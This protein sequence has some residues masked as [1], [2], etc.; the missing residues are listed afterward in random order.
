MAIEEES[1]QA[2]SDLRIERC[3][4]APANP[5]GGFVL[6]WM[7]A[8]RRTTWNHSLGRALSWARKFRKPLVVLEAV[9]C[10]Y[11][12]ASDRLHHFLIDGMA[13][14]ARRFAG[15]GVLYY[16]YVEP[17]KGAGKGLLAALAQHACVVVTDDFP[18]GFLPRMV[19]AAAEQSPVLL[20]QV[21]SNGLLPLRAAETVFTTAYSFR[22][23]LQRELPR[24][25]DGLPEADPL[26]RVM[27]PPIHQLPNEIANRW[28]AAD[29]E[30]LTGSRAALRELPINHDV[31]PVG[32]KGGSLAGFATLARF[33]TRRLKR[34]DELRRDPGDGTASG[35]SP[36]LHFGHVSVYEI[37]HE[38]AQREDWTPQRLSETVTGRKAGWWGMSEPA[39][40]FLDELV[41]WRELGFNF[42]AHRDDYD[43][44][45]SLPDWARKT[46]DRHAGDA[47]DPCYGPAT[48]EAAET[49]D[50]IWNAAQRQLLRDGRIHTYLRMLWGKKILEWSASPREALRIMIELN[51]KYAV[52]GRDPNSYSGIAWV[53]GRYDRPWGPERPVFGTIRYMSSAS[54]ARKLNL[55]DYLE[56]YGRREEEMRVGNGE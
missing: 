51:N 18:C 3:N 34:Y 55:D 39:E 29:E 21:D 1:V 45:E 12:W 56:K 19:A 16:P 14:N 11:P 52:D 32:Y 27:I 36:Y 22:R 10:D 7:I 42:C 15:S 25:L 20:E 47:R 8:V 13:D 31:R 54:T 2:I 33:L 35:L 50:E 46:L 4:E 24:H 26:A 5:A 37:L 28:P 30:L 23:F 43:T 53:L 49:H 41:T 6:Y 17:R 48:F 40:A 9:R 44:Y 38:L